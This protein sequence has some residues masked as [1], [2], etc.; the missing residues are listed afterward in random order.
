MKKSFRILRNITQIEKAMIYGS[1]V[2]RDQ[3]YFI[4][5]VSPPN[6]VSAFDLITNKKPL[7]NRGFW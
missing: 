1:Y 3:E 2:R 7:I 6:R 5:Y 4:Q